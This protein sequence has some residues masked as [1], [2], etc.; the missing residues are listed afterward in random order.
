M[1]HKLQPPTHTETAHTLKLAAGCSLGE[2]DLGELSGLERGATD[3]ETI[4]I[5]L[6]DED[7]AVLGRDRA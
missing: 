4:N 1:S 6:L 2:E 5:G 3:K 7:V